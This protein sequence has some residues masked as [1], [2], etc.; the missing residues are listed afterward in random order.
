MS[1]RLWRGMAG[2]MA[3]VLAV[4][5]LFAIGSRASV[6]PTR[7]AWNDSGVHS[8]VQGAATA[9]GMP[10]IGPISCVQASDRYSVTLSWADADPRYEYF[11]KVL[12]ASGRGYF[13]AVVTASNGVVSVEIPNTSNIRVGQAVYEHSVTVTPRVRG[14]SGWVG[15]Q[16]TRAIWEQLH[17][18]LFNPPFVHCTRP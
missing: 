10:A 7:A 5:V 4:G 18:G 13:E 16:A 3:L 11:V 2:A 14:N 1:A 6:V 9:A 17:Y 15:P 8:S 12:D